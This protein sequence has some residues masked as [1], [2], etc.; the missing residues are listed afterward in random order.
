MFNTFLPAKSSQKFINI[1]AN[2]F[3]QFYLE[4]IRQDVRL[5]NV[6]EPILH[7]MIQRFNNLYTVLS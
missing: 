2:V 5:L 4:Y 7:S 6:G 1:Q 3:I